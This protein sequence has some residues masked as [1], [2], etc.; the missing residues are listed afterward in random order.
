MR[1]CPAS[2]RSLTQ[3]HANQLAHDLRMHQDALANADET[4]RTAETDAT[5]AQ[6]ALRQEQELAS[7]LREHN[8]GLQR[9]RDTLRA[10]LEKAQGELR[11]IQRENEAMKSR[12]QQS[13]NEA[14]EWAQ[15][16]HEAQSASRA[17]LAEANEAR[18]AAA[19]MQRS[20]LTAQEYRLAEEAGYTMQTIIQL[21]P[22]RPIVTTVHE[23][24]QLND[25][26]VRA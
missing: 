2:S 17:A 26:W 9:E 4:K 18:N 21:A 15:R 8:E 5:R 1:T 16:A 19:A 6:N 24:G 22:S 13:A 25:D 10:D 7:A 12:W 20:M 14:G 3:V 23:H 11:A